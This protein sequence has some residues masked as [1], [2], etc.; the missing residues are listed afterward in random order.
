[1]SPEDAFAIFDSLSD[2]QHEALMLAAK[3]LTS[4]QIAQ[5]LGLA[6]VTIDK[7]IEGVRSRLEGLPRAD[8]LRLYSEWNDTYDKTIN[9][10]IILEPTDIQMP[11]RCEQPSDL[12]LTFSDNLVLDARVSWEHQPVW[13]RP[14]MK[15]SELG[16]GGKLLAMLLGAVAIMAVAVLSMAFMNAL[17]SMLQ[18]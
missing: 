15:P 7:R 2:K 11:E 8:L 3:H 10:P 4:K 16:V 9:G 17:T 13:L 6:P 14:G 12:A 5:H 18:R 1:M